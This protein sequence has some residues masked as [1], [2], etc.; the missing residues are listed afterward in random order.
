MHINSFRKI[1]GLVLLVLFNISFM[2]G[3][4]DITVYNYDY[5]GESANWTAEYKGFSQ[6]EY[7][8]ENGTL[9]TKNAADG[10]LIFKY[11]GELYELSSV[12]EMDYKFIH[13]TRKKTFQ[14][15]PDKKNFIDNYNI[16]G[17]PKESIDLNI[18]LDGKTE[19][20]IMKRR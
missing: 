17:T 6:V 18:T 1:T 15:G 8:K 3:C 20:I 4:A 5:K 2:S 11:K 19:T 13:G 12:K 16:F 14:N 10:E 7:Y 9:H